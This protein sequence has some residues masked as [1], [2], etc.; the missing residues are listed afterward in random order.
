MNRWPCTVRGLFFV[1]EGAW[2]D[3]TEITASRI[4]RPLYSEHVAPR[5]ARGAEN[6]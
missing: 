3:G 2:F 5:T 6:R 4:V 1:N